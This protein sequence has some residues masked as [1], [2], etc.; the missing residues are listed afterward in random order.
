MQ[1][2]GSIKVYF[3]NSMTRRHSLV[4]SSPLTWSEVILLFTGM[5]ADM[6]VIKEL[7][8]VSND[9]WQT[10]FVA[11][12]QSKEFNPASLFNR[13]LYVHEL[14]G[15]TRLQLS[16]FDLA[17]VRPLQGPASYPIRL[18]EKPCNIY[19]VDE[20]LFRVDIAQCWSHYKNGRFL[21]NPSAG[22]V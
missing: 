18:A 17:H 16:V 8:N 21:F 2:G 3:T 14:K 11:L 1:D 19:V 12:S 5:G 7:S 13:W 6:L 20:R 9:C 4:S 10:R 22:F 15:L